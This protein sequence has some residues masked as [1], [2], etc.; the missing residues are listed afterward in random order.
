[1]LLKDVIA[2]LLLIL[3]RLSFKE[4]TS[5]S[6]LILDLSLI[7]IFNISVTSMAFLLAILDPFN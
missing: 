5:Y 1:M 2:L 3:P 6:C 7:T 4:D